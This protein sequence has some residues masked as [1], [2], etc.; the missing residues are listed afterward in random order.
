[1]AT[2]K[3]FPIVCSSSASS[4]CD[5]AKAIPY[6]SNLPIHK[7]V[8]NRRNELQTLR[9]DS[10]HAEV[11]PKR[12]VRERKS[13]EISN[14]MV[15]QELYA[16]MEIVA[17]RAEMHKNIGRQRDNWNSLLLNSVNGM[18]VTAATVAGLAAVSNGVGATLVA[19]KL[20]SGLLY[21]AV[22]GIL[23]VM[24][25]IQPSQLAEE[26]R[27]ATRLF[28]QLHEEI[29]T[30]IA[31]RNPTSVHVKDAMERVLALDEAY[32]LPLLG[33][34]L[35]KFPEH[36]EPAVWWPQ[37]KAQGERIVKKDDKN[38]WNGNLEEEMKEIVGILKLKD[39]AEYVRL[40]KIV[41]KVNKILAI[42]GPLFTGSAAIASAFVGSPFCGSLGAV[43][44]VVF[45]AMATVVNTLEHGGQVGMIFEMYRGSAGFFKLMEES[46]ESTLKEREVD[47]RE[48]G[49]VF[50]VKV[51]LELGRSL[52]ELK[53]LA[54]DSQ[55]PSSY[56]EEKKEFASK[57]F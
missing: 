27:N 21:T 11:K 57:L 1:M 18:T 15:V 53:K 39:S 37:V 38:G 30:T 12:D 20:S 44:G 47:K 26:Q 48:N 8:V 7:L 51:A 49:E 17:D 5:E 42:C 4:F 10:I 35:D 45:G 25:K 33:N 19:L 23:L 32:P 14:S 29:K 43:I 13:E 55:L 54:D 24:N 28:K 56:R 36:V 9:A 52:P 41:L 3:I 50:E 46:I 22:T 34:M 16:I 2:L 6:T 40:S 31:L